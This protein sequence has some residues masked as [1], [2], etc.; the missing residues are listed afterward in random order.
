MVGKE[1]EGCWKDG[2]ENKIATTVTTINPN[3]FWELLHAMHWSLCLTSSD[4][5]FCSTILEIVSIIILF[6]VSI[7]LMRTLRPRET[8]YLAIFRE[9][10]NDKEGIGGASL[11][12]Q[13][14]SICLPVQE[15]W[16]QSLILKDSTCLRASMCHNSWACAL[17]PGNCTYW[18]H[19]PQLLKLACPRT[20]APQQE[21]PCTATRQQSPLATI[22]EKPHSKEAS[23]VKEKESRRERNRNPGSLTQDLILL[24]CVIISITNYANWYI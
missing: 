4:S 12:A 16:V 10:G 18:T 15:T 11:V 9:A 21:K 24:I 17:E 23:T 6:I 1:W 22:R 2:M 14:Y 19:T 5:L 3:A 8:E 20:H 7:L 13:W